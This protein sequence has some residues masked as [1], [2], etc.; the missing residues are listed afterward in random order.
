M[1][2][3]SHIGTSRNERVLR[4]AELSA[5]INA[6][7]DEDDST[8]RA[9]QIYFTGRKIGADKNSNVLPSSVRELE[10]S[11]QD[12]RETLDMLATPAGMHP[13]DTYVMSKSNRDHALTLREHLREVESI[14]SRIE[15]RIYLFLVRTEAQLLL[16]RTSSDIFERARTFVDSKLAELAPEPLEQ[17]QAAYKRLQ[18]G[19][20]EARSHALTSCRRIIKTVAD[21]VYPPKKEPVKG[22]DGKE[23]ILNAEKYIG[24]LL[25]YITETIGPHGSAKVVSATLE[26][27]GRRLTNLNELSSKGVHADITADE[28]DMCIIQTYLLIGEV[29]RYREGNF[30]LIDED[31]AAGE[32]PNPI[33]D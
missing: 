6:T 24:R 2:A 11:A 22:F 21:L 28:A 12:M 17:F 5:Q 15:D 16:G 27:L 13:Q 19:D 10:I 1:E 31:L 20:I 30:A 7:G 29:L 14:L 9:A 3:D 18:E 26:S 23:R 4:R 33:Q 8:L 25:Q 32:N